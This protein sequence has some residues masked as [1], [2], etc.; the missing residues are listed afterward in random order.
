MC[1]IVGRILIKLIEKGLLLNG[2]LTNQL[3]DLKVL[4]TR[5]VQTIDR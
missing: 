4:K 3:K 2:K 5:D 1:E